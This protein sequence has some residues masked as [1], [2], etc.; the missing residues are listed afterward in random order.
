MEDQVTSSRAQAEQ[1]GAKTIS[2]TPQEESRVAATGTSPDTGPEHRQAYGT[3]KTENLR[4]SGLWRVL[5]PGFIIICCLIVIAVP[6]VIL[7]A[8]LYGAITSTGSADVVATHHQLIWLWVV[9]IILSL[10]L[11][12]LVI[13]YY[14]ATF[15]SEAGSY[16]RA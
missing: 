12:A 11:A 7:I 6:M 5:L 13:R 16:S 8:L 3:A 10:G 2:A 9:M 1:P 4:D 14:I 15:F